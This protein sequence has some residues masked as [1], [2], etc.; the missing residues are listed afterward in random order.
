MSAF[1]Y[2]IYCYSRLYRS[3]MYRINYRLAADLFD[4]I[5]LLLCQGLGSS[6]EMY[7]MASMT[8]ILEFVHGTDI[9]DEE[10]IGQCYKRFFHALKH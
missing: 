3:F 1:S 2:L 10:G 7:W 5:I 9:F 4:P 6:Y 8:Y